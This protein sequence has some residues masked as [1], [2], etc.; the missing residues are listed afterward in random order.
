MS[1]LDRLIDTPTV[2]WS[3]PINDGLGGDTWKPP[4]EILG[5]WQY[6]VGSTG[7]TLRVLENG[8][9]ITARTSVWVLEEVKL[10]S[11]LWEGTLESL[12]PKYDVYSL[13]S[14][15]VSL[16]TV[17]SVSSNF[18]LYKVYLDES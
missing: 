11:Y 13:A 1:I 14:R 5:K 12:E 7:P 9:V 8:S 3:P 15:V 4:T 18:Y 16:K 2:S 10:G 6:S 17:K